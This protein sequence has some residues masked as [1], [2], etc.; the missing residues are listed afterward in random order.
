MV[1]KGNVKF[2]MKFLYENLTV[3]EGETKIMRKISKE[4]LKQ[5]LEKHKI[6]ITTSGKEGE[7][8]YLNRA[9][10][11]G[12]DLSGADLSRANLEGADLSWANLSGAD[13]KGANLSRANLSG[14]NLEG[15]IVPKN[16]S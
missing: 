8:A 5:I 7:R 14:A 2:G 11:R 13:L 16:N 9:D 4:E 10:L 12:A 1:K 3:N 6:Y 15:A